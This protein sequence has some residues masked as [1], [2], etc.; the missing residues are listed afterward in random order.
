MPAGYPES[1]VGDIYAMIRL[2]RPLVAMFEYVGFAD[3]T[4]VLENADAYFGYER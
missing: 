3:L 1:P 4:Q 2:C